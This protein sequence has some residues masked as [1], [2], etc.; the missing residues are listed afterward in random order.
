MNNS[1]AKS[2]GFR[3]A[4]TWVHT[5]AGLTLGWILYL[6]FVTGTAGYFDTELD[7]WMQ[8]ELPP[9]QHV[10]ASHTAQAIVARMQEQAPGAERWFIS[11]PTDRNIPYPNVFWQGAST[12][13]GASAASGR[14]LLD[15]QTA[16]PL[17]PRATGGGQTLYQMHWRLHYLSRQYSDKII[18]IATLFM[19]VG[20][21][22]GIIIHKNIFVDFFTLRLGKGR[23]SW[24][25]AHNFL[26]VFALPFHLMITY[27]GLLF[28]GF[29]LMPFIVSSQY[30]EDGRRQFYA[31]VFD[32]PGL[33]EPA[34]QQAPLINIA[35]L[36]A[37]LEQHWGAGRVQTLDIHHPGDKN[38]RIVAYQSISDTVSTSAE[39]RV[40]DG[41]SGELLHI[42]PADSSKAKQVR[43]VFLGLHEGL[44]AQPLLRWLYFLSGL[45]GTGMVATGL[46]LWSVKRRQKAE[47][48]NAAA[49]KGLRLVEVLNAGTIV[50]LPVAIACY[51]AANR[52][53]PVTMASRAAWEV[54]TLFMVW[55]VL[56]LWVAVRPRARVW[57]ELLMLASASYLLL[58]LLNAITTERGL[59][60]SV[61]QGD[62]VFA[63][64]DLAFAILGGCFGWCAWRVH[65]LKATSRSGAT[66]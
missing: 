7:R 14:V 1:S 19:M 62:W 23:R 40:Y 59:I 22:T 39:R 18:G 20:L 46:I 13:M 8:P 54:H 29:S 4:M 30:P 49:V 15:A 64:V 3:P 24:L 47:R 2:S 35:P 25:D 42:Q 41:V 37:Q 38:A 6:I 53:L 5:W 45:M 31:E 21:I 12:D 34:G 11:L 56:L 63:G 51:F 17:E 9:I 60:R 44:F 10:N 50:G 36:M 16:E 58:P 48:K 65:R 33:I 57:Q 26:S 43:D 66:P 27:S 32:P 28:L 55:L 52:L 61:A